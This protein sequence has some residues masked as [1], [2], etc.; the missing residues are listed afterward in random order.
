[1]AEAP[2]IDPFKEACDNYRADHEI[3]RNLTRSNG[4]MIRRADEV[5]V[6]LNPTMDYPGKLLRIVAELLEKINQTNP[7]MPDGSKRIIR[8]KLLEN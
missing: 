6:H 1:M 2:A 8:F 4:M 3:F 5:E 7:K